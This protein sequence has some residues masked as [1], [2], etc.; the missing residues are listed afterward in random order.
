MV[1][2][3]LSSDENCPPELGEYQYDRGRDGDDVLVD[4]D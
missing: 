2:Y 4:E 3:F 1:T